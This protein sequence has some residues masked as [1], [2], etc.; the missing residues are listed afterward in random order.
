MPRPRFS[1]RTLLVATA[2]ISIG[3]GGACLPFRISILTFD[4]LPFIG[5]AA[6][7][8]LYSSSGAFICGGIGA[9]FQRTIQGVCVGY[10]LLLALMLI[11]PATH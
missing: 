1:L 10:L 2:L 9:L 5:Q 6:V 7:Y 4:S 3:I 11:L 8:C